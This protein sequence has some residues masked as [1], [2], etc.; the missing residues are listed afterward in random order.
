MQRGACLTNNAVHRSFGRQAVAR[1]RHIEAI[2]ERSFGDEA[3]A[4]LGVALPI[5]AME[6]QQSRRPAAICGEEIE[7]CAR[8]IAIGQIEMIGHAGAERL[9][10][11]DPIGE[12]SVA[13]G[14]GGGVVVGGV[15]RLLIHRAV[16]DH[17][18]PLRY[19]YWYIA[20]S[21]IPCVRLRKQRAAAT[22][23]WRPRSVAVSPA[24]RDV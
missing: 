7:S 3:E 6:E 24:C 22:P 23:G 18:V 15:E 13:I 5:T 11:A 12:I 10:A 20:Q 4:L 21:L 2:G 1:D 17:A 8:R 9:A 16:N 19:S 14:H